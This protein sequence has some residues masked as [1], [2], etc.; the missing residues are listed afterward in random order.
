MAGDLLTRLRLANYKVRTGQAHVPFTQL[1]ARSLPGRRNSTP[2]PT[3]QVQQPSSPSAS[4]TRTTETNEGAEDATG[5]QP[6][7]ASK[8]QTQTVTAPVDRRNESNDAQLLGA[9]TYR[10]AGRE[11]PTLPPLLTSGKPTPL[12][13]TAG[14]EAEKLPS[15]VRRGGAASSLLR[16]AKGDD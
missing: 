10:N 3:F 14:G 11:E 12:R 9:S 8:P 16:L 5:Q 7:L 2:L 15:S 6:L 1:E 13:P 4:Q